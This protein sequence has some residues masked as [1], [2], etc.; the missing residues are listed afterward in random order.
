MEHSTDITPLGKEIKECFNRPFKSTYFR[1]YLIFFVFGIGSA[2]I[3]YAAIQV[4]K[5][6]ADHNELWINIVSVS[7]TLLCASAVDLI[8]EDSNFQNKRSIKLIS[9]FGAIIMAFLFI[10]CTI[11]LWIA[12]VFAVISFFFSAAAWIISNHDNPKFADIAQNIRQGVTS[13]RNHIDDL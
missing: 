4:Y 3:Y 12:P 13:A 1:L 5:G 6:F 7:L 10:A 11:K 2:D 8:D 9:F